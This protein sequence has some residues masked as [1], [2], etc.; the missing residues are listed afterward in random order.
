MKKLHFNSTQNFT[1]FKPDNNKYFF[2]LKNEEDV[3]A[4]LSWN[5]KSS[6]ATVE[7]KKNAYEFLKGGFLKPYI[8]VADKNNNNEIIAKI[9]LNQSGNGIIEFTNGNSYRFMCA[10][11]WKNTW[12]WIDNK[13]DI[14]AKLLPTN[15]PKKVGN[16]TVHNFDINPQELSIMIVLGWYIMKLIHFEMLDTIKVN[17]AAY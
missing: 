5:K 10:D 4:S 13:N 1:W 17:M 11:L 15:K 7:T 14:I 12:Q 6:K 9:H 3:F 8:G 2:E 16:T